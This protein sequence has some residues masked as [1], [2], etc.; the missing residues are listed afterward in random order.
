MASAWR[1]VRASRANTAFT[2]EGPW[3][4]GGRW[5][6]PGVH[7]VYVSEHQS[8]AAFEVFANRVPFILEEK[9]KAYHLEWPDSLTEVFSVKKLLANWRVTPPPAETME[10]G[11]RWVQEQRSAVLALPSAISPDDTNFLLNPEHPDFKRIRIHS[12]IN[13]DFDPRLLGR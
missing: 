10:I 7:V 9:Y 1:I 8:T 4:Y 3:R 6:S 5:N 2:G 13:F 12:A 11:D